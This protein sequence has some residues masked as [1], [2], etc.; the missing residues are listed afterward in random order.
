MHHLSKEQVRALKK[1]LGSTHVNVPGVAKVNIGALCDLALRQLA[2]EK[3]PERKFRY[4]DAGE[5]TM[6]QKKT[7]F[8]AGLSGV[9][10]GARLVWVANADVIDIGQQLKPEAGK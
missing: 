10:G 6:W 9:G 5:V 2:K 3:P 4:V 7:C 1:L 8:E